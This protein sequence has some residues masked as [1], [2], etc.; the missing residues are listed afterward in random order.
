M[1]STLEILKQKLENPPNTFRP[2]QIIHGMYPKTEED[3][4]E[5]LDIAQ[6]NGLGG[7]VVNMDF[8]PERIKGETDEEYNERRLDGYLGVGKPEY[9]HEWSCLKSFV[10]ACF[11]RGFKVW[12]YDELAYPSGAAG[13]K[14]LKGNPDYCVKGLVCISSDTE[15]GVGSFDGVA[16]DL[17][18]A[19]AY[20]ITKE[21][22]LDAEKG[23]PVQAR[24]GVV[25]YD[26]PSGKYKVCA[27]Y[28]KPLAF[29]TENET[30]YPDLLR[31]DVTDKFIDVTH[32]EY[33]KHLGEDIISKITAFF[34][35]EPSLSTHGCSRFF[36]EVGAV[37]AWT[38]E[39]CNIFPDLPEKCVDIFFDTKRSFAPCD[40]DIRRAY[41]EAVENLFANNYFGRIAAWCEKYGTRM[42]GHLYG[43]ETLGMQIG[44]N[45]D[46][47]GLLR[48]MQMPGV[49]RLYCFDPRDVTAEKTATSV[50]H[51]YGRAFTMSENSFHFETN[52]WNMPH[53]K[54]LENRINSAF[55]QNQLGL[56]NISSYFP[57]SRKEYDAEWKEFCENTSRAA[58]FISTGVHKADVFVLIPTEGAW[59][60]YTPQDHKYWLIG[61]H[62]VAPMQHETLQV[63]ERSYGETLLRLTEANIDYDLVDSCSFLDCVIEN[64]K[65]K[66]PYESFSHLVVFDSGSFADK[67]CVQI[68][69]FLDCGGTVTAV[70]SI[71]PTKVCAEWA[72]K[73]PLQ[74]KFS[75]YEKVC[76][77]VLSGNAKPVLDI[78]APDHVRVRR[79]ETQ[80]AVLWFVHNRA[81]K[82]NVTV[83]EIGKFFVMTPASENVKT[84]NSD[85]AFTIEM[86]A[87][88]AV[89][90]VREK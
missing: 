68:E 30:V 52:F 3:T 25:C 72:K 75:N 64:G 16:G 65:I 43:E 6:K 7:F 61:P 36:D 60:Q 40:T 32:E 5:Y 70:S 4:K 73:Y 77:T 63:L 81:E 2:V 1:L 56:T 84:V 37:C 57:Y 35:D 44:L 27:F 59:E 50:A 19:A 41:W 12:I 79:S 74:F 83:N 11:E 86:A 13:N 71:Y 24:E 28:T 20:P 87:K 29:L 88:S 48:K 33:R 53:E 21:G 22:L 42:T 76:E 67:A 62:I 45:A 55:Y 39:L 9:E 85:G 38:E 49:D 80:D 82:C 58:E 66:T 47:F 10:E 89:M 69:K 46:L 23:V 8:V 26:L 54:S 78:T 17:V 34:T 51:M 15:G 31:A 18:Y 90:L 14:V